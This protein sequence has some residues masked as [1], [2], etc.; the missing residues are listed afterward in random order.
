MHDHESTD[1]EGA[2]YI[3]SMR[4]LGWSDDGDCPSEWDESDDRELSAADDLGNDPTE[5]FYGSWDGPDETPEQYEQRQAANSLLYVP[6]PDF[7]PPYDPDD[8]PF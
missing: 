6:V 8:L 4:E 7:L 3:E 1:L 5:G 2:A